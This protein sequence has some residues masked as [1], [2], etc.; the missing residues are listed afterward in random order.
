[1]G[2]VLILAT[3]VVG[4]SFPICAQQGPNVPSQESQSSQDSRSSSQDSQFGPDFPSAGSDRGPAFPKYVSP[5]E[6]NPTNWVT[7]PPDP[8]ENPNSYEEGYR[9]WRR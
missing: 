8:A 4:I 6:S 2:R 7:P 1:M 3:A 5:T 9:G